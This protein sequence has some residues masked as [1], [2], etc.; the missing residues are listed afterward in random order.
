MV[1]RLS[2]TTNLYL[3]IVFYGPGDFSLDRCLSG[4]ISIEVSAMEGF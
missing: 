4:F 1:S 3:L 2:I